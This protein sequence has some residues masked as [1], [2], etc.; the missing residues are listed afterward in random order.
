MRDY[1]K[2]IDL[3][4]EAIIMCGI[5]GYV[6]NKNA[7]PIILNSLEKLEY[8]GYDSSGIATIGKNGLEI[9]KEVG[10]LLNLK[11]K[12]NDAK[13]LDGTIGIGHTRW[14]THG[15]PTKANA[16]PH[17]GKRFVLVHNGIIENE[18]HIKINANL[19]QRCV[20]GNNALGASEIF[21]DVVTCRTEFFLFIFLTGKSLNNAHCANVFFNGFV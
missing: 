13:Q 4:K 3:L 14:A 8:R 6:G 21:S 11:Q 5:V 12:C 1:N 17:F 18:S 10:K 19:H 16:H 20:K 2:N 7:V 9:C 15:K